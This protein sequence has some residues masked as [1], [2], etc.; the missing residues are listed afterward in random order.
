MDE[1][2]R[3]ADALAAAAETMVCWIEDDGEDD[4]EP[5]ADDIDHAVGDARRAIALLLVWRSEQAGQQPLF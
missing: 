1:L 4:D 3:I 2:I 5:S